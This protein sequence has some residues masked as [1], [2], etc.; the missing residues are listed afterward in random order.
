MVAQGK[1]E[2]LLGERLLK[3]RLGDFEHSRLRGALPSMDF[4]LTCGNQLLFNV[5]DES[6]VPQIICHIVNAGI[7]V[8]EVSL[9]S[10]TLEDLFV[11]I[12]ED[13][14]V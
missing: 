7:D 13:T 3:V 12:V 2:E 6:R 1:L 8:Y 9:A 5:E 11:E 10:K 14:D 4:E